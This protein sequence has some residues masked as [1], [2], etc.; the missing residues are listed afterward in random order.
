MDI[1]NSIEDYRAL[2][3][4]C[5]DLGLGGDFHNPEAVR[6][7]AQAVLDS[8]FPVNLIVQEIGD[9]TRNELLSAAAEQG[10]TG[11]TVFN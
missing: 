6:R 10:V 9:R 8:N 3:Q 1:I 4:E 2:R 11:F 7:I 5:I